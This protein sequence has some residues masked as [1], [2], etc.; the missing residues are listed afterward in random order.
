MTAYGWMK[1]EHTSIGYTFTRVLLKIVD[2]CGTAGF[3]PLDGER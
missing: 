3:I 1:L 2:I